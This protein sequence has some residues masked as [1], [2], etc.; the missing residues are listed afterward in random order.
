MQARRRA[1]R[2]R[3][4]RGG[5]GDD[6]T[7]GGQRRQDRNWAVHRVLPWF[8]A[9]FAARTLQGRTGSRG[10]TQEAGEH[11]GRLAWPLSQIIDHWSADEWNRLLGRIER[12][13]F[14]P[15]LGAGA[16][17]AALPLGSAVARQ[18][19]EERGYPLW[20]TDDLAKVAQFL[21][22]VSE[23]A[24]TPKEEYRSSSNESPSLPISSPKTSLTRFSPTCR[25]RST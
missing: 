18:W 17:A 8:V 22:V 5:R 14:T 11:G 12:G 7:D 4:R 3:T 24:M 9:P 2:I 25:C 15:F 19:A 13:K 21:A 20:D 23:D 16:S 10:A 6:Q 1:R